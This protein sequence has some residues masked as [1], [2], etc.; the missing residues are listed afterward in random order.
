MKQRACGGPDVSGSAA[1]FL[2]VGATVVERRFPPPEFESGYQLP[3]TQTPVPRVLWLEYLDVVVLVAALVL[4]CYFIYG[5][6]SRRGIWA[7]SIFSL[8][9][10]GFYRQ[11]CVCAI[12]APQN[13]ALGLFDSGYAVPL[14]VAAFFAVPLVFSLFAG[15]SFC[16]AVCPHGALQDLV[17]LKPVKVPVWLEQGLGLVPYFYLGAGVLFAATG[18]AFLVCRYDPFVPLFR[19]TGSLLLLLVGA[20]FVVLGMFVGRPYCRFLCPYGA[21]L[22]L[23]SSVAKWRVRITPDYCTQC[24]LCE[25]SCP[26]GVIREPVPATAN[27]QSLVPDRRRLGWLLALLPVLIGTGAWLG[28]RFSVPASKM[29]P[30]VALAEKYLDPAKAPPPRLPT[31]ESLALERAD[32]D[33]AQIVRTAADIRR[34]LVTAGWL[35]GGWVGLVIGA[36]LIFLSVR[37]TRSDYEP[38]RGACVACARCFLFCPNERVRLGLLPPSAIPPPPAAGDPNPKVASPTNRA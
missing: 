6:R 29:H 1:A 32:Q 19:M 25:E 15:R 12:G 11:G 27:P 36:K 8:V 37:P 4:A 33:P 3:L 17:L 13:I 16:A 31:P 10:F 2:S 38:D 34:R 23:A 14:T 18:S 9:Y 7:L 24:R 35:F 21:L 5:R 30:T 22:R 28:A 20:G 26:F